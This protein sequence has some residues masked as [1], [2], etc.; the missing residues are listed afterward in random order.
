MEDESITSMIIISFIITITEQLA[1]LFLRK[2]SLKIQNESDNMML[3]IYY[4][5]GIIFYMLVAVVFHYIYNNYNANKINVIWACIS[6]ILA[7]IV[8]ALFENEEITLNKILSLFFA[9]LSIFFIQ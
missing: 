6:I 3:Y 7:V 4:T 9:V 5:I 1:Q 8:G 2:S